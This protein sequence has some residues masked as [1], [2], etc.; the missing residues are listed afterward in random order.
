[1]SEVEI[2]RSASLATCEE[3]ALVLRAVGI[4]AEV[5]P[6]GREYALYVA[7]ESAAEARRQMSAF[8]RENRRPLPRPKPVLHER[9][10]TGVV[11]YAAVVI[12]VAWLASV[13]AGGRSWFEA[14][15]LQAGLVR[16]GEVWRTITALMLHLDVGHLLSN[17]GFGS[18]FGYFCGQLLGPGV[19]WAAILAGGAIGNLTNAVIQSTEHRAVG[20]STAVFAALGLLAT[21]SL[22]LH[23]S[24]GQ[25]WAYRWGPLI[26]G[27]ALLGFT[28]TG[29]ERTDIIAH[30]TGFLAGAAL[31]LLAARIE[32]ARLHHPQVQRCAAAAA[33]ALV[34]L[35]WSAAFIGS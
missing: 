10:W 30:A 15:R 32:P 33:I 21:R 23:M 28:G 3:Y 9:A 19:A 34:L 26:A 13:D 4:T 22:R 11:A 18:L 8:I 29:G 14:G 12:V 17:L 20:A 25:S 1:M 16:G 24:A 5:V 35:A 31:G 2:L 6:V 7:A 27:V